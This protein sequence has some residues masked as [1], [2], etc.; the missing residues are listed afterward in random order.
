MLRYLIL[1]LCIFFASCGPD[2]DDVFSKKLDR[3]ETVSH[4]RGFGLKQLSSLAGEYIAGERGSSVKIRHHRTGLLLEA[5]LGMY[6]GRGVAL[7]HYH[8]I[9]K[10][11]PLTDGIWKGFTAV[12]VLH[13]EWVHKSILSPNTDPLLAADL[14]AVLA[15][16][17]GTAGKKLLR[18][19]VE[20]YLL[21]PSLFRTVLRRFP[22]G[23][24]EAIFDLSIPAVRQAVLSRVAAGFPGKGKLLIYL[25]KLS[26]SGIPVTAALY[27]GKAFMPLIRKYRSL[28]ATDPARAR[29]RKQA[30]AMYWFLT[31]LRGKFKK[32]KEGEQM[33]YASILK[34]VYDVQSGQ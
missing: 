23:K 18:R 13:G 4:L 26:A 14:L 33:E 20:D 12:G 16:H 5:M 7:R 32:R 9:R 8:V 10:K 29:L 28:P 27:V 1:S 19:A 25:K 34:K 17:G 3:K 15:L 21:R 30:L 31:Q 6:G 22:L 11:M 2:P 24:I